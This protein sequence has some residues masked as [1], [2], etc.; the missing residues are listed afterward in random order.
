MGD[1]HLELTGYQS[2]TTESLNNPQALPS[3][4]NCKVRCQRGNDTKQKAFMNVVPHG[5]GFPTPII[6]GC[7]NL[8]PLGFITRFYVVILT[9]P[10]VG[11]TNITCSTWDPSMQ[12]VGTISPVKS[13]TSQVTNAHRT[14]LLVWIILLHGGCSTSRNPLHGPEIDVSTMCKMTG[15]FMTWGIW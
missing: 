6:G 11:A 5:F 9:L 8:A 7:K 15:P 2:S 1:W 4:S 12:H 3:L 10:L 13:S 14:K